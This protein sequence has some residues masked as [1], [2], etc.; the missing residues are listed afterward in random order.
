MD[1]Q[2]LISDIVK[3]LRQIPHIAAI[4]LGGSCARGIARQDSDID[5]GVY[6]H[7]RKPFKISLIRKLASAI[8]DTHEAVV[9]K[10]YEWGP[11][12]NGGAWLTVNKQ[13]IDLLYGNIEQIQDVITQAKKGNIQ[14]DF[15][16]QPPYGFPSYIFLGEIAY[17]LPLYDP[18]GILQN[19]KRQVKR[20]PLALKKK[21][22]STY[23]RSVEFT[24][25]T[26]HQHAQQGD[27]YNTAGCLTRGISHLTQ[28]LFAL[29][30]TY[31]TTDKQAL[32]MITKFNRK[33][34]AYAQRANSILSRPGSTAK[35][36]VT[37]VTQ[38]DRLFRDTVEL[39]IDY[40]SLTFTKL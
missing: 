27:I 8:N 34:R 33:P 17:A 24:L 10:F 18:D 11:W 40:Y 1:R 21:I 2:L 19:L 20:Y 26:A 14:S 13:R 39:C 23:L 22:I 25:I 12:V 28:V 32:A 6:Y 36:L 37:T 15:D 9:T 38:L 16:Q 30:E 5:L 4:S 7:S 3:H 29:N 35:E 31:F